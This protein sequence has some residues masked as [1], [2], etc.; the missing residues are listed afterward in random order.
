MCSKCASKFIY[1]IIN[2]NLLGAYIFTTVSLFGS[3]YMYFKITCTPLY[4]LL[5][6]LSFF[7]FFFCL[8]V[9]CF[10][11][12]HPWHMEVPR[13]GS[14]WSCSC[15]PQ[16]QQ[17]GPKLHLRPTLQLMAMLTEARYWTYIFMDTSWIHFHC[18]TTEIPSLFFIF[19]LLSLFWLIGSFV[20]IYSSDVAPHIMIVYFL[21]FCI[22]VDECY[23]TSY[24]ILILQTF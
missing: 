8:F 23:L 9:F 19:I 12:P 15:Q 6:F 3:T 7:F 24:E 11:G 18:A 4:F 21:Y 5:F 22:Y 13:L 16:P 10:F 2:H 14:N 1:A 20:I 17:P